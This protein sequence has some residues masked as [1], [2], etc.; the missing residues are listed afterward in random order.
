MNGADGYERELFVAAI[1]LYCKLCMLKLEDSAM[2]LMNFSIYSD[3]E[4]KTD[5]TRSIV[6]REVDKIINTEN[7]IKDVFENGWISGPD[8][9][10]LTQIGL[11]RFA[12]EMS[13]IYS[14]D[15]MTYVA[16]SLIVM[17]VA[18]KESMLVQ[19]F[20]TEVLSENEKWWKIEKREHRD[21]VLSVSTIL[22]YSPFGVYF[23]TLNKC[24]TKMIGKKTLTN[25]EITKNLL[26][27][28]QEFLVSRG[29]DKKEPDVMDEIYK[30]ERDI[31][32][33]IVSSTSK[34]DTKPLES[35]IYEGT[36]VDIE[37]AINNEEE[38]EEEVEEEKKVEREEVEE[39]VQEPQKEIENEKD[40]NSEDIQDKTDVCE[41]KVENVTAD[42]A[43]VIKTE[44][45]RSLNDATIA[46][47]HCCVEDRKPEKLISE[48]KEEDESRD[49]DTF[50]DLSNSGIDQQQYQQKINTPDNESLEK[51]IVT[52]SNAKQESIFR[53][54]NLVTFRSSAA[55]V[56]KSTHQDKRYIY[57]K[58]RINTTSTGTDHKPLVKKPK[59]HE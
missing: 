53:A 11:I 13:H 17:N 50:G 52:E 37:D 55:E 56:P 25:N 34:R 43:A 6:L 35:T 19:R 49:F 21:E 39:K 59:K 44:V 10:K 24:R 28:I 22:R 48:V 36:A 27:G 41:E 58:K 51:K 20:A 9:E 8:T 29:A 4:N 42:D 7:T 2:A 23:M 32:E 33:A 40:Q 15:P 30:I 12:L 18:P 31:R 38:E 5:L 1:S 47:T 16:L 57:R 45:L 46:A 26:G 3:R 54:E 14:F